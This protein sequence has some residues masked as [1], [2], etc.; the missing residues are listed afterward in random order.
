LADGHPT[1]H[2]GPLSDLLEPMLEVGKLFKLLRLARRRAAGKVIGLGYWSWVWSW[3]LVVGLVLG[4]S[5][6]RASWPRL[7]PAH[8]LRARP[9]ENITAIGAFPPRLGPQS[10]ARPSP[11]TACGSRRDGGRIVDRARCRGYGL[12]CRT[13]KPRRPRSPGKPGQTWPSLANSGQR[14][15]RDT[16]GSLEPPSSRPRA[17]SGDLRGGTP[18]VH[19]MG[20]ASRLTIGSPWG[21]H[22]EPESSLRRV[23]SPRRADRRTSPFA[24]PPRVGP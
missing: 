2:R 15:L 9:R 22:A 7:G 23:Q 8:R 10:G 24:K 5:N 20:P 6:G 21:G 13:L 1:L 17:R 16:S 19:T 18:L 3:V 4:Q 14:E 11:P 12:S